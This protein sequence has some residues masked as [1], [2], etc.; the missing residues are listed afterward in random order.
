MREWKER[1]SDFFSIF[2]RAARSSWCWVKNNLQLVRSKI[3]GPDVYDLVSRLNSDYP[4]SYEAAETLKKLGKKAFPAMVKEMAK[5]DRNSGRVF[6][7][8][9]E[10]QWKPRTAADHTA[11]YL[12]SHNWDELV[13]LGSS[14]VCGLLVM[15]ARCWGEQEKAEET[16]RRIGNKV[17]V[18]ALLDVLK[19]DRD[20]YYRLHA[21]EFLGKLGD[22]AAV[23]GLFAA[24]KDNEERVCI[25]AL[26]ALSRIGTEM[27]VEKLNELSQDRYIYAD[28]LAKILHER[29][30]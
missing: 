21:A 16:L 25:Y 29:K 9:S 22:E 30:S 27:A 19:N 17:V 23:S 13:K 28:E 26:R 5:A 15:T 6:R 14:A 11:L 8:L 18:P 10:M 4:A 7:L 3:N 2:T 12:Q 20:G 24:A 1:V